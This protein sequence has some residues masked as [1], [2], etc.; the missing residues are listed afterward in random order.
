MIAQSALDSSS[1][2]LVGPFRSSYPE[3]LRVP[4]VGGE[5]KLLMTTVLTAVPSLSERLHPLN[6][7]KIAVRR[8]TLAP[9]SM[10]GKA[11]LWDKVKHR[12][13]PCLNCLCLSL[14]LAGRCAICRVQ[15]EPLHHSAKS[16]ATPENFECRYVPAR[17][18]L[19]QHRRHAR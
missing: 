9:P 1:S 7:S 2:H 14:V 11:V 10:H 17:I 8:K 15:Q 12:K 5:I 18:P 19:H 4:I 6:E 16:T 3:D 13:Q